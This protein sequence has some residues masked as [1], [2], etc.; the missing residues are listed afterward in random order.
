MGDAEVGRALALDPLDHLEALAGPGRG[1]EGG[2]GPLGHL[3]VAGGVGGQGLKGQLLGLG[4]PAPAGEVDRAGE[5]LLVARFHIHRDRLGHGPII[6][7]Q[8]D[9]LVGAVATLVGYAG[10]AGVRR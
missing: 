6:S 9:T 2:L 7:R 4:G 10:V 3:G 8:R 1:W 5:H